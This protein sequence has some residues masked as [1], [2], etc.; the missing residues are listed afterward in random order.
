MTL[1]DS[2]IL[3]LAFAILMYVVLDG[4]DLGVGILM[5]FISEEESRAKMIASIAPVWDGNETWLIFSGVGLFAVFPKVYAILFSAIYVPAI[6]MLIGL[7]IRGVAFEFREI[8]PHWRQLWDFAFSIGSY[9]V[10]FMQGIILAS[11]LQGIPIEQGQYAGNGWEWLTPFAFVT[12]V[13]VVFGYAL[14]GGTWLVMKVDGK[15]QHRCR[16]LSLIALI[17]TS[18]GLVAISVWTPTLNTYYFHKWLSS[19]GVL[20]AL[21]IAVLS[22]FFVFGVIKTLKSHRVYAPFWASIGLFISGFAGILFTLY[23]YALPPFI[24]FEKA[25]SSQ[26]SLSFLLSGTL[27]ILPI[28]LV[29]FSYIHWT[30]RGKVALDSRY[31]D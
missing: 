29:Y 20:W 18:I 27:I 22:A 10:A 6:A 31:S 21:S 30:F 1:I 9:T 25:A 28:I 15:L 19:T 17:T 24:T 3:I 2:W 7:I 16:Q 23:P 14:M 8:K 5:P 4:F 13:S 11:L 12:G 26:Q